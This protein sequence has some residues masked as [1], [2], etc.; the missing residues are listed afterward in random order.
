MAWLILEISNFGMLKWHSIY[1]VSC[2]T[3]RG[4]V[5][6]RVAFGGVR[7]SETCSCPADIEWD[8]EGKRGMG[9][10]LTSWP[11]FLN[12][13]CSEVRDRQ[14]D[15]VMRPLTLLLVVWIK[16]VLFL[17]CLFWFI[18]YSFPSWCLLPTFSSTFPILLFKFYFCLIYCFFFPSHK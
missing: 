16:Q 17:D 9:E 14:C 3:G 4:V 2:V 5:C 12:Q 6:R 10:P 7:F 8:W 11:I 13:F 15:R 1:L 18:F